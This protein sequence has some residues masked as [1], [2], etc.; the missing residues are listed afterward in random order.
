[1]AV[2]HSLVTRAA[3]LISQQEHAKHPLPLLTGIVISEDDQNIERLDEGQWISG[4]FDRNIRIDQPTYGAGQQHAHIYGRKGNEIGV[5]NIDGSASH[6]TICRLHDDDATAL[7]IRGY[8]V[9]QSN[10][11]E[12]CILPQQP[13]MLAG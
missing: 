1:M 4:R 6:G 10:I 12:W 8:P 2:E 13:I 7:R 3:R 11:V 5:I 9:R